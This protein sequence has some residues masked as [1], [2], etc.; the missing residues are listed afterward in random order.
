MLR[1]A[2]QAVLA[3]PVTSGVVRSG[4]F[5]PLPDPLIIPCMSLF[6]L[7]DAE[8]QLV[9]SHFL[10][11]DQDNSEREYVGTP[12]TCRFCGTTDPT[13]FRT[14][15]HTISKALG[16]SRVVSVDE[17]D[18]CNHKLGP[19]ENEL[20]RFFGPY[21]TIVGLVSGRTPPKY[22]DQHNEVSRSGEGVRQR[23]TVGPDAQVTTRLIRDQSGLTMEFGMPEVRFIPAFA[24]LALCKHAL[25]I[26]PLHELKHFTRLLGFL[27]DGAMSFSPDFPKSRCV[28]S[29]LQSKATHPVALA[30]LLYRRN[31]NLAAP[32]LRLP[33]WMYGLIVNEVMLLLPLASDDWWQAA[34]QSYSEFS[35][36]ITLRPPPPN[37]DQL[38]PIPFSPVQTMDFSSDARNLSPFSSIKVRTATS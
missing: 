15:A 25:S 30:P 20:V 26:M 17:C 31:D 11:R 33:R 27:S 16:N 4:G 29:L 7:T 35:F 28:V 12:G 14:T 9:A 13:R 5:Q 37:Y 6:T 22:K 2:F 23:T 36:S 3:R 10:Y 24:Y 21:L 34:R 32:D 18:G 1:A 8:F 38:A 19:L